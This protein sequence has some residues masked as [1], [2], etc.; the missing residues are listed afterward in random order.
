MWQALTAKFRIV[1]K[2][3]PPRLA[4][5][6]VGLGKTRCR[7]HNV[8]IKLGAMLI[9][10]PIQRIEYASGEFARFFNHRVN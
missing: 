3:A 9:A 5:L 8:L 4:E 1:G 2:R 10:G 7:R 6:A